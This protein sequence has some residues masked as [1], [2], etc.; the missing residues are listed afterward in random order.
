[1]PQFLQTAEEKLAHVQGALRDLSPVI[2]GFSGGADSTLVL[3]LALDALGPEQ[4]LAATG[5]SPSIPPSEQEEAERIAKSLGAPFIKIPTLELENENYRLNP[6]NRCFF[7]KEE[8]FTKLQALA[9]EKGYKTVVDG[10]NAD[11]TKDWRPGMEA[12][13]Q[14][15]VR[16]PLLEAGLTKDE[17]RQLSHTLGLPTW[18]KPAMP[19]LSSRV[20]YGEPISSERL[21]RIDQAEKVLRAHGFREVRVRDHFP[22]ARIEI[23]KEE[24][25]HLASE[26]M[27]SLVTDKLRALGYTFV[28]LDLAGYKRGNLNQ[29]P[30]ST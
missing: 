14:L 17:I 4:V 3:K 13:R 15:S 9:K 30:T 5:I 20:P 28:T 16:S 6:K 11:D 8:L 27:R 23:E 10:T 22:I 12:A 2:V 26:P 1:M 24:F 18:N 25:V 19:C 29:L 21:N 7:C